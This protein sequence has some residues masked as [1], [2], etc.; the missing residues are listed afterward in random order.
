MDP[1]LH[2]EQVADQILD[3]KLPQI[4]VGQIH[5]PKNRSDLKEPIGASPC[6]RC[7]Q[8]GESVGDLRQVL[9]DAGD[10]ALRGVIDHGQTL[11][12]NA[13]GSRPMTS[14]T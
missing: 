8:L 10:G 2:L 14:R 3:V 12:K 4:L 13:G 5:H 11:E 9:T 7:F 6:R 1:V